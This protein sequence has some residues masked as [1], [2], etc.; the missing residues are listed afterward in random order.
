MI[1]KFFE[2]K[3]SERIL[4]LF[5]GIIIG[6]AAGAAAIATK[7][8]AKSFDRLRSQFSQPGSAFRNSAEQLKNSVRSEAGV[9]AKK[10]R[11]QISNPVPDLY[12][13]T[14]NITMDQPEIIYGW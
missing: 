8:S 7:D 14:E 2:M 13:A 10:V 6:S 4:W 3:K 12:K 1:N 11:K 9:F 5:G